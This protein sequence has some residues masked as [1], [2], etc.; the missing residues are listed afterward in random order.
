MALELQKR[1]H[2]K[3]NLNR[4]R[5][6]SDRLLPVV[7]FGWRG[8]FFWGGLLVDLAFV[9]DAMCHCRFRVLVRASSLRL[10][11]RGAF[12]AFVSDTM[13]HCRF[14]VLVRA[15]SPRLSAC[16]VRA[17]RSGEEVRAK[18]SGEEAFGKEART[19]ILKPAGFEFRLLEF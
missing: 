3:S 2:A 9:S 16:E 14:R 12:L 8:L 19:K 18:R 7:R 1:E 10:S 4:K 11:K 5:S 17:K 6:D 15:S 13:C